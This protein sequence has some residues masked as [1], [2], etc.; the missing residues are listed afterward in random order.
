M[1][2]LYAQI[3]DH[4]FMTD[5]KILFRF[6]WPFQL[7]NG[8]DVRPPPW[9]HIINEPW[10]NVSTAAQQSNVQLKI[11]AA[12]LKEM[13]EQSGQ[14]LT[15]G[16]PDLEGRHE[17]VVQDMLQRQHARGYRSSLNAGG[18]HPSMHVH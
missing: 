16:S 12:T 5:Q 1:I 10:R 11:V 9:T 7:C 13:R 14:H 18:M 15:Y 3:N 2:L 8:I 4:Q 17:L 6:Y